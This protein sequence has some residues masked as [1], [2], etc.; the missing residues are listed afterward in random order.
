MV[1][2]KRY[3][4]L[5]KDHVVTQEWPNDKNWRN[6]VKVKQY[7]LMHIQVTKA[8]LRLIA[9]FTCHSFTN[10]STILER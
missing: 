9:V 8:K 10:I 2:K 1:T 4:K 6:M 3:G 7:A 5:F